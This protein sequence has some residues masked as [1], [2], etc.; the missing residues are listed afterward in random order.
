MLPDA[1]PAFGRAPELLVATSP[2]GLI[3]AAAVAW[4]PRG[5]PI[6]LFVAEGWRRQGIGRRL[7]EAATASAAGETTALRAWNAVQEDS[8]A[9]SFLQAVGFQVTRRLLVFETDAAEFE[10]SMTALLRR[11]AG[12]VPGDVIVG[13][14]AQAPPSGVV[15][16]VA[17]QFA[18]LPHDVAWRI[19]SG[20]PLG[21]D[22]TLSLVLLQKGKV[23]G[24]M[25][26]KRSGELA[27]VDVNVVAPAFRGGWAN[28]LLLEAMARRA[29]ADGV[30]HFRFSCEEHVRDTL[31]L[32]RRSGARHLPPNVL[33]TKWLTDLPSEP[34]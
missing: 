5:F 34:A 6:L 12:K 4:V 16:L 17:P 13:T 20:S 23:I 25:L 33:L 15:S 18:T 26:C 7:L 11:M 3:G 8:A 31:N 9:A 10:A 21:Y 19:T 28:L 32:A 30:A 22:Q 29:R 27:E 14:L 24:A 2:N 1:F